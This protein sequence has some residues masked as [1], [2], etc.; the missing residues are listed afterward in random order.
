MGMAIGALPIVN[1][2]NLAGVTVP[3]LLVNAEKDRN[4]VP[5]NTIAAYDLIPATTEKTRVEVMGAVH[6]SFDSTYCAQMQAAGAAFDTDHNGTVSAAEAASTSMPLDRWNL[7]LIGA[8][9]PGFISGKAV[10]YCSA[11]TFTTPVNIKRLV[12]ATPNAEYGCPDAGTDTTCGWIPATTGP[13]AQ[14]G[15]CAS[16]ITTPPCTGTD[17]DQVKEQ[18]V[19]LAVDFFKTKLARV[20]SG[21]VS[22]T[23]PA[24]LALT[25]GVPAAFGAFTPGVAKDY[26]ASTT[27]NVIS[28]AGD[29]TLSVADPSANATGRLVNGAFSLPQAVQ[30]RANTGA[31]APVGGSSSPT[32]LLTYS[33]P[34]SNDA[35]TIGF[36]QTI[37]AN[38]ALRTGAYAKTLTFT[39]STSMP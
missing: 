15:V 8:S 27:A 21:D 4:T 10:H 14:A 2:V 24:T 16:A 33:N 6:R 22:A 3:T 18:M 31:Y 34:I 5:A 26:T 12:A 36:R 37:G 30:A 29:A 19:A 35:V 38:D 25:L 9:F 23:V 39:L 1:S 7:G 28:T 11:A 20:A 32:T 17:T 13:A